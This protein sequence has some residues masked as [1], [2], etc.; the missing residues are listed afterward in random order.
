VRKKVKISV[1]FEGER[2]LKVEQER[3]STPGELQPQQ[4][5]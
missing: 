2:V 5:T 4:I 1:T 3:D